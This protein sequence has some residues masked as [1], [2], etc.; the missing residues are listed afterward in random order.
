MANLEKV[1]EKDIDE[2]YKLFKFSN[3][4]TSQLV[5]SGP[6]HYTSTVI[7]SGRFKGFDNITYYIKVKVG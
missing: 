1:S 4:T 5:G 6:S 3:L 7:E 2:T